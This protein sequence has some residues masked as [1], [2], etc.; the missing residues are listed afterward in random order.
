MAPEQLEEGF[1]LLDCTV[2]PRRQRIVR[3]GEATHVEPRVM[4]VLVTLAARSGQPV[5]RADLLAAVWSDTVVGDEVLSRAI[6][7]LR[8]ALGDERADPRFIQTL[9]RQGYELV[10]PVSPLSNQTQTRRRTWLIAA[11]ATLLAFAF[12]LLALQRGEMDEAPLVMLVPVKPASADLGGIASGLSESLYR[13]AASG[14]GVSTLARRWSFGLR[15]TGLRPQDLADDFGANYLL[16]GALTRKNENLHL[17][18]EIV[19]LPRGGTVWQGE[20]EANSESS[21]EELALATARSQLNKHLNAAIDVA[22]FDAAAQADSTRG[23]AY[24]SYLQARHH[25]SLRGPEH[26][27]TAADLLTRSI[28]LD[29]DFGAA[30]LALAQ[31]Q[32][33]APFYNDA[34]VV[35]QFASARRHLRDA[36]SVDPTLEPDAQALE[37]F[38][39]LRTRDWSGATDMLAAAL[40]ADPE[41]ALAHYWMSMLLC[42]QGEHEAGLAHIRRGVALEPTSPVI[43]DRLAV[44]ELWVGDLDAAGRAFMDARRLGYTVGIQS[45]AYVIY[46]IRAK[47]WSEL[48]QALN[49]LGLPADWVEG[50]TQALA[51]DTVP[52]DL[53]A[54]TDAL[55]ASE[56]IP[57]E[58][59]FGTW[60]VLGEAERAVGAFD[61]DFKSPDVELLWSVEGRGLRRAPGFPTLLARLAL[62]EK[63]Q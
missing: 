13:L 41:N 44:N 17:A 3:N 5:S 63:A 6:S 18:L 33:L 51:Q 9:P 25:W 1:E 59:A 45:K 39:R 31:V 54:R 58:L 22:S 8:Q 14:T 32:A 42:A 24:R 7:L 47:R 27:Q 12:L 2:E 38:M 37:G 50:L 60:V 19:A 11:T 26:I 52:E 23:A 43:R 61:F 10:A 34:D 4:A 28:E 35:T 15:E 57:T 53:V 30:H 48:S 40:A 29:T 16:E 62:E 49:L 21:L 46:L 36:L 55:I 20:I 56:A